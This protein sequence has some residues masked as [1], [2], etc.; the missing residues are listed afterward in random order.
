MLGETLDRLQLPLQ[1]PPQEASSWAL[2]RCCLDRE[3]QRCRIKLCTASAP[4]MCQGIDWSQQ[5]WRCQPVCQLLQLEHMSFR[6]SA[7][8]ARSPCSLVPVQ[9]SCMCCAC[10]SP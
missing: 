4:G 8:T 10:S 5:Q 3:W 2:C 1:V 6:T 9:A 7:V